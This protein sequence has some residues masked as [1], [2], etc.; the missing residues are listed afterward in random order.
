MVCS[1]LNWKQKVDPI[2]TCREAVFKQTFFLVYVFNKILIIFFAKLAC[3]SLQTQWSSAHTFKA[4]QRQ[5]RSCKAHLGVKKWVFEHLLHTHWGAGFWFSTTQQSKGKPE[6]ESSF[7]VPGKAADSKWRA[8]GAGQL[9]EKMTVTWVPPLPGSL[10]RTHRLSVAS[11]TAPRASVLARPTLP[12]IPG[13]TLVRA[14]LCSAVPLLPTAALLLL[15]PLW[16][17]PWP[18]FFLWP[19]WKSLRAS[20][21]LP[22]PPFLNF[23]CRVRS[24]YSLYEKLQI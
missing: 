6:V 5:Q 2:V 7:P 17:H 15:P 21:Y 13:E 12:G 14:C 16:V 4:G 11:A 22:I 19:P 10:L 3:S 9:H 23:L 8:T 24:L 1:F 20:A 18:R